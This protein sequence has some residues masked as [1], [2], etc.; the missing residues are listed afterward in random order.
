ME[1]GVG[2]TWYRGEVVT[3]GWL[4]K[5]PERRCATGRCCC[6]WYAAALMLAGRLDGVE[7]LLGEADRALGE[8]R[9]SRAR[10][11]RPLASAGNRRGR[12]IRTPASEGIAGRHRARQAGPRAPARR[13]PG[14]ASLRRHRPGAGLPGGRRPRGGYRGLRR[15]GGSGSAAGHDYIALSAMASRAHLQLARADCAKRTRFC[16]RP[17]VRSRASRAAAGPGERA[18]RDGRALLRVE[19]AGRRGAPPDGGRGARGAN[20]RR[21]DPHVG[22]YSPLEGKACAG[23]RGGRLRG[24]QG[25]GA[26]GPELGRR[27][28]D[29]RRGSLEGEAAPGKWGSGIRLLRAEACGARGRSPAP[30]PELERLLLA[31][32]LVARNEPREALQ[33]LAQL[34]EWQRPRARLYR[35]WRCKRWP[36]RQKARE[37]EP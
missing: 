1:S 3:L 16:E 15:G 12:P 36:C 28:S 13:Q 35:Y 6:V 30:I 34:R 5:L 7:S 10:R 27:R 21:R 22:T 18:H 2:Q 32:L 31:R 19:R 11:G 37:N 17:R 33:L 29:R 26:G 24:G 8:A 20:G 25:S 9:V 23:R 14:P 4:Q